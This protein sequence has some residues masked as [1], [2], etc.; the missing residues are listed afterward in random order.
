MRP[1]MSMI[2]VLCAS[3][4][5]LAGGQND[6]ECGGDSDSTIPF[7]ALTA[8][9]DNELSNEDVITV[10]ICLYSQPI[11]DGGFDLRRKV[12][13]VTVQSGEGLQEAN[14]LSVATIMEQVRAP[15]RNWQPS[16][17]VPT[18]YYPLSEESDEIG[19][20]VEDIATNAIGS[21]PLELAYRV[22]PVRRE[23]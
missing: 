16:R 22:I 17:R 5:A 1:L 21:L 23:S 11:S 9:V 2:M 4:M 7:A 18:W 8:I 12:G 19:L 3:S 13:M 10:V 15:L 20:I 14:Y 6:S